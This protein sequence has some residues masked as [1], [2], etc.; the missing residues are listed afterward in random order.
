MIICGVLFFGEKMGFFQ[1]IG[2]FMLIGGLTAFFND[3]F[4]EIL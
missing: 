3:H 1:K 4:D 2:F